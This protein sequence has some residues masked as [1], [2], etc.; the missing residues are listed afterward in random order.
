MVAYLLLLLLQLLQVSACSSEEV[1]AIVERV[2]P[3][4]QACSHWAGGGAARGHVEEGSEA[5]EGW[6]G[7]GTG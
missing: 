2:S 6:S 7:E 5:D 4:R 3:R 1:G